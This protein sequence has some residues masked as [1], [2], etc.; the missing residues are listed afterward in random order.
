MNYLSDEKMLN[1]I[2]KQIH[3]AKLLPNKSS[4]IPS[5][6]KAQ[7]IQ[8][9][10]NIDFTNIIIPECNLEFLIL[11]FDEKSSSESLPCITY[12]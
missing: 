11:D 10:E 12:E 1:K 5:S 4:N 3:K 2:R 7:Y 6:I 9:K 8:Q